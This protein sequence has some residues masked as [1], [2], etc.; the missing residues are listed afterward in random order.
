MKNKLKLGHRNVVHLKTVTERV[1]ERIECL[2]DRGE[3][4][5]GLKE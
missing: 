3:R 5:E 1:R 2:K 4:I